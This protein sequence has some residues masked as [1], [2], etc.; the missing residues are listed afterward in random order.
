MDQHLNREIASLK[1]S[2]ANETARHGVFVQEIKLLQAGLDR[3]REEGLRFRDVINQKGGDDA[4]AELLRRERDTATGTVERLR[5]QL[6]SS[7]KR[8]EQHSCL[9]L[10]VLVPRRLGPLTQ[11]QHVR[12]QGEAPRRAERDDGAHPLSQA[13]RH[14]RG[15]SALRSCLAEVVLPLRAPTEGEG[16]R[17][18]LPASW[19]DSRPGS[20]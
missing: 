11:R 4:A 1:A 8:A 3:S 5:R 2:L 15:G 6:E 16:V 20:T 12:C 19:T 18:S 17:S 7:Q 14:S 10:Y 13:C 9:E